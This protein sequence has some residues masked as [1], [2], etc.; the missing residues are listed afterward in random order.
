MV[1]IHG[2]GFSFGGSADRRYNGSFIVDK[3]VSLGQPIVFV[4]LN[5]RLN[6]LGFPNS[7]VAKQAG[8]SNLGLYDQRLALNWIKENIAAFGGDPEKITIVGESAGGASMFFHLTAY[9]GRDD[10]LFR[11]V[12]VESGYWATQLPTANNTA[13]A[14]AQWE[15]LVDFAGCNAASTNQGE[16]G[17]LECL[18]KVP[19]GTIQ[20]WSTKATSQTTAFQPIVDGD[21]VA[22]DLQRSFLDG[23]FVKGVNVLLNANMDE[24]ISFGVYGVNNTDQVVDAMSASQRLPDGWLT[25]AFRQDVA[26]IYPDNEDVYPPYQA[27][28]GLLPPKKVLGR[29]DRR[30]AAIFGDLIMIAPRRQAAELLASSSSNSN[31]SIYVSRFDQLA[32][33]QLITGGAQ[34]FQEVAFVFRNP[35][36]SQNA[37]G[38]LTK[39]I[40]LA[41]EMSSYWISFVAS[42][43]P[44]TAETRVQYA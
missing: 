29:N 16:D 1:W 33:N 13:T 10:H 27:G 23:E 21:L 15:S 5:Y 32:Y 12:A 35:L 2:G 7:D 43:D 34:H 17:E 25:D 20:Q 8:V 41:D 26:R 22:K 36:D 42:G 38:P 11:G 40:K 31:A 14:N 18:R 37:L 39:D 28:A 3:S 4:S 24:G 19:L 6:L 44:N 30:S 9:G